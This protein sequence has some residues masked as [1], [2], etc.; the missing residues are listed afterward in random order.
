MKTR[1]GSVGDLNRVLGRLEGT[2]RDWEGPEGTALQGA[3]RDRK[4]C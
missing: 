2:A 3:S 1:S 4:E